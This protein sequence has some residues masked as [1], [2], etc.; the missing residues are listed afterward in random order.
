M[1]RQHQRM[2]RWTRLDLRDS[3]RAMEKY[4]CSVKRQR[5]RPKIDNSIQYFLCIPSFTK[6]QETGCC[7][8]C[9]CCF[10]LFLFYFIFFFNAFFVV[11]VLFCLFHSNVIPFFDFCF[12]HTLINQFYLILFHFCF[13]LFPYRRR[14]ILF[15]FSC[16]KCLSFITTR[17]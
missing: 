11:V 7:C 9:C 3:L 13:V 8:C 15:S 16:D 6:K 1:G 5:K 2:D 17:R 10:V 12:C 4:C 14:T